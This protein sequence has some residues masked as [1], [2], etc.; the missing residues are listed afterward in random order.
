M[1]WRKLRSTKM[2]YLVLIAAIIL[3]AGKLIWVSRPDSQAEIDRCAS[4]LHEIGYALIGYRANHGE[5]FPAGTVHAAGI[6]PKKGLSWVTQLYHF[7]DESQNMNFL[8]ETAAPWHSTQNRV[9]K[10]AS[11]EDD[12]T[13]SV[14]M[15]TR[16]P[17]F[18]VLLC[19]AAPSSEKSHAEGLIHYVGVA[20]V[21]LDSP[22][23]PIGHPKSGVFGYDRQT[24][25]EDIKDGTAN[26]MMLAET[27]AVNGPWIAGGPAT[28]RGLDP[29]KTPY[30]G[31]GRQFGGFHRGGA[32]VLFADGSVRLVRASVSPRAF[33]A[34]AT[35]ADGETVSAA[36]LGKQILPAI[37][38]R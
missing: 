2:R 19:S 23:L 28:V 13:E 10:I 1:P 11:R 5:A 15:P 29:N 34:L 27:G 20:G 25:I 38:T 4:R 30:V 12:G 16:L 18:Y 6:A 24:R 26:T 7:F 21:S 31:Q 8:F 32:M 3:V 36:D 35:I 22:S 17:C 37:L 14:Y 33:E 9:P